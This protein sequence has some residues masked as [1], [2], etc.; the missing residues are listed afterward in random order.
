VLNI[1][2]DEENEEK[3]SAVTHKDLI[4]VA[5]EAEKLMDVD[6]STKTK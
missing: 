6:L 3:L 2:D 4:K 5:Q 1:D